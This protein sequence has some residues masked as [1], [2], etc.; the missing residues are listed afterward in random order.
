MSLARRALALVQLLLFV[1]STSSVLLPCAHDGGGAHGS[2]TQ[3]VSHD[4]ASHDMASHDMASRESSSGHESAP[5]S[6]VTCPWVIG[7]VGMMQFT[8]D[9]SWRSVESSVVRATP[10]GATLRFVT[11][12]R[13]IE[14]PPPRA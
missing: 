5:T 1:L 3:A 14:S 4:V 11:V 7:C 12:A 6:S 10:V 13:D 8:L 9:A 2:P